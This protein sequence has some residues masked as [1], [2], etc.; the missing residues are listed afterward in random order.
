MVQPVDVYLYFNFRS[1]YCY[2]ASKRLFDVIERYHVNLQWRP[3]GGWDG[4]SP[5]QDAPKRVPLA[6]QDM[7]RWARRMGIP[8]NPPPLTTE[9]TIAGAG[10]LY[11][12]AAGCL[13]PY[14]VEVMRAAYGEG[15]DIGDPQ[16]LLAIGE[17]I[18]LARDA[19]A[20]SFEDPALR[21]QLADNWA[22]ADQKGVVGV[23]SFVVG[24]QI[25]WGNDRIEFLDEHLRELRLARL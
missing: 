17:R 7:A 11:A 19:L 24:E 4:R 6:R 9:P 10:S 3:L 20:A 18:G 13:R 14:I 5:P 23:P 22:E 12:E 15:Q 16:V 25:F 8:V 21:R 1:P 2:L